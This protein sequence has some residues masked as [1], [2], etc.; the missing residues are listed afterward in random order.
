M[1]LRWR[2]VVVLIMV[3]LTRVEMKEGKKCPEVCPSSCPDEDKLATCKEHTVIDECGCCPVCLRFSPGVVCGLV[4]ACAPPLLCAARNDTAT[5][6]CIQSV[7]MEGCA[8]VECPVPFHPRCPDDARLVI[9]P[10]EKKSE[11]CGRRGECVCNEELCSVPSCDSGLERVLVKE[12]AGVPGRC[13][14]KY[15]CRKRES[16][17]LSA[18]CPPSVLHE[19][20]GEEECPSDSHR[21]P[22]H[23]V[24]GACCP[25]Q[26]GCRCR[27]SICKPATCPEGK[28]VKV[29]KRGTGTPGRCCDE[30]T[31]VEEATTLMK[32]CVRAGVK[33]KDGDEWHEGSCETCRCKRGVAACSKQSCPKPPP[34]CSWIVL[35]E[36]ECC[37]VCYGCQTERLEKKRMNETWQRDD[38][39]T[40]TC[41]SNGESMC[42]KHMCRSDCENPR[43]VEGQCCPVCDEPTILTL[44]STCPSLEHCPLR[45]ENGLSRDDRGC[46][47]CECLPPMERAEEGEGG[48]GGMKGVECKNLDETNCEKQCA[49]GYLRNSVGCAVCRCAKCPPLHLCIKH[50]LYGFET[51]SVGCPVCK[52][53]AMA[54]IDARLSIAD[55]LNRLS[56][57][58][59]CVSVF[60][61]GKVMERDGGEWWSD[62]CRHCFCEQQ[63]EFCSLISC[64]ERPAECP[65][66]AWKHEDGACCPSC[67]SSILTTPLESSTALTTGKSLAAKHEHTVCQSPGTGRLFTDGE[68]W[69]L[70]PCVSCTCRVGHVLCRVAECPPTP[71]DQPL[72]IG[73]NQCCPQCPK[74][75]DVDGDSS[76]V[77]TDSSGVAH[78]SGDEWRNDDCTSCVC[79]D[80]KEEC[81]KQQCDDLATCR[82][83]PLVLKG[84]CCPVCSDVLS[85][86]A[87][88]TYG[89][90]VYSVHE[91]WRDGVCR[92][93]SCVAGGQTV[94][95]ELVCP[96]CADPVSVSPDACCPLCKDGGWA[97]FGEGNGSIVGLP[98]SPSPSPITVVALSL[99][100][101]VLL[102]VL[103]ALILFLYRKRK[104]THKKAGGDLSKVNSSGVLLTGASRRMGSQPQ[105]PLIGDDWE[106]MKMGGMQTESLLG[107]NN[108][109]CS[110]SVASSDSSGHGTGGSHSADDLAPLTG[111]PHSPSTRRPPPSFGAL[112]EL[113]RRSTPTAS[114]KT[115][116]RHLMN[117]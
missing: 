51:N 8:D 29:T 43:K 109:E 49:H 105:L 41:S 17:C 9:R 78:A 112:V 110:A 74:S 33:Y 32:G 16:H 117:P 24:E 75:S 99:G 58:D 95:R 44:P 106:G 93:C 103:L 21:P 82:G 97:S 18:H 45:C 94:C 76:E 15:E 60:P 85:S 100:G 25:I 68:T 22:S 98:S 67:S 50:C 26:P 96:A 56:G 86:E 1:V 89:N 88:C 35:P 81:F 107:T 62:G 46:F 14:D 92:N 31:C 13:C 79:R 11:C 47:V 23:R 4:A 64:P 3:A 59:K 87:V 104:A 36:G 28:A 102:L 116:P 53:R 39:T 27:A 114:P 113:A 5:P 52:C 37:P 34:Q 83:V 91:E 19:N 12:G 10:P 7:S 73:T 42:E 40:C 48:K 80:G 111:S 61:S 72:L 20:E 69:Q 63:Q 54:R 90:A 84:R 30:W 71:C 55:K 77:C 66:K 70:A 57:K 108:S 101:T 38:C 65:E 6:K 2:C 115:T